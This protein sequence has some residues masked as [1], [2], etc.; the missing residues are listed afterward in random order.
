MSTVL[1][2]GCPTMCFTVMNSRSLAAHEQLNQN[3]ST[4]KTNGADQD[5]GLPPANSCRR[6]P[7]KTESKTMGT[8]GVVYEPHR[9]PDL[10]N[11]RR[12][13]W[14]SASATCKALT[15]PKVAPLQ[16]PCSLASRQPVLRAPTDEWREP[17]N[18]TTKL[19]DLS[20]SCWS[21]AIRCRRPAGE[22]VPQFC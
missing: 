19:Y 1:S 10:S 17:P 21:L 9:G 15:P 14:L 6:P 4:R 7:S 12:A 16:R 13:A 2:A 11:C 3:C 22:P 8:I 20:Y 5:T 18:Q